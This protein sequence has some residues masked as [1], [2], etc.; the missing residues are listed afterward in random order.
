MNKYHDLTGRRVIVVSASMANADMEIW[1]SEGVMTDVR[2]RLETSVSYLENNGYKIGHILD[3][4]Y[5]VRLTKDKRAIILY[6]KTNSF[7]FSGNPM[8]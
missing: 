1:T 3:C 4:G 6:L 5:I 2:Q 7:Q 8:A